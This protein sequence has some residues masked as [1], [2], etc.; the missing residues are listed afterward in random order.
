MWL[1][2]REGSDSKATCVSPKVNPPLYHPLTPLYIYYPNCR[3][4]IRSPNPLRRAICA[5][6]SPNLPRRAEGA[7][8]VITPRFWGQIRQIRCPARTAVETLHVD[9]P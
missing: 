5:T 4:R 2:E 7:D 8:S 3:A 1:I 6:G 9:S